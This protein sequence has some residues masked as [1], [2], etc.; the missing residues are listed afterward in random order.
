MGAKAVVNLFR[1]SGNL[2]FYYSVVSSYLAKGTN[3]GIV[4]RF[5]FSMRLSF[6]S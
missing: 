1:T 3:R 4:K 2:Y 5:K 6:P